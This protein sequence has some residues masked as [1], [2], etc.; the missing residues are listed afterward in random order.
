MMRLALL[1]LCIGVFCGYGQCQEQPPEPVLK[2]SLMPIY[3][4]I[5]AI[6]H[7]EGDVKASFVVDADGTVSSVEI[8]SGPPLLQRATLENIRS[9]KFAPATVKSS[10]NRSFDTVFYYRMSRRI[11][12][13]NNRWVTVSTDSFREIEITTDSVRVMTASDSKGSQPAHRESTS[14]Q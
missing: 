7:I 11:A 10:A 14:H 2:T 6:A 9:W 1:L 3:P 8:V 4:A 12:C 13:E 5:A